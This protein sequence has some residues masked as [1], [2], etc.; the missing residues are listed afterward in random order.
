MDTYW[1]ARREMRELRARMDQAF[2]LARQQARAAS[3]LAPPLDLT[4]DAEGFAAVVD[5][6]GVA[7]DSL[8]VQVERGAV[9]ITGDKPAPETPEGRVLRRE[10]AYG[11]F[12][13]T[14]A[15]PE[16]ADLAQVTAKLKDGELRVRVGRK[17]EAGPRRVEVVTD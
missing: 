8:T 7:R 10:R 17:V 1:D 16:E 4:V 2:R 9:T 11:A 5:L 15:L 13:R 3:V 14:I 6:P 12:R